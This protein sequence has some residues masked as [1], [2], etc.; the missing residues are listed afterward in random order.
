MISVFEHPWLGGLF[1]DEASRALFSADIQLRHMLEIEAAFSRALGHVGKGPSDAAEE[2]AR[3]IEGAEIDL[4]ALRDG[5]GKDGVVVPALVRQLKALPGVS[6]DLVHKGMTSQDVID[7]SLSLTLKHLTD[8]LI[9]RLETA[10]TGVQV[11]NRRYG[12]RRIMGRTRMQAALPVPL[13]HR[14]KTWADPLNTHA[15]RLEAQ[16]SGVELLQLGGPVGTAEE[17]GDEAG[18]I[19]KFMAKALGLQSLASS[20]HSQRDGIAE[21]AS[22]LS[23]ISGSLGKIGMDLCLMAQQGIDEASFASGG[24]SSA[25]AHK[26]NPV[27]AELLVTLARFNATQVSAMHHALVHEQERS[28]AAWT[29]EWMVLPQMAATTSLGLANAV[30][31]FEMITSLGSDETPGQPA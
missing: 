24:G 7:T 23:L 30:E 25:M 1:A 5:T 4:A 12:T 2:T 14:F 8:I 31:L 17:L 27:L 21:Y 3:A 19:S 15:A 6:S 10:A 20:W 26:N 28:G 9:A 11:L 22:T 29:L 18:E 16:R 13:S